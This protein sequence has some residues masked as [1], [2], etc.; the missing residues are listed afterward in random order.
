MK[1][2]AA[3]TAGGA[4]A[5]V[6]QLVLPEP[7]GT[8]L[9]IA[10]LPTAQD[11]VAR[12][13]SARERERL[14]IVVTT[15]VAA[16]Q[17]RIA[18]GEHSRWDGVFM[19]DEGARAA[20]VIE[21]LLLAAEREPESKKLTAYSRFLENLAFRH[22]VSI[23]TAG[24][25]MRLHQQLSYRQLCALGLFVQARPQLEG[26]YV[27]RRGAELEALLREVQELFDMQLLIGEVT[28]SNP[29]IALVFVMEPLTDMGRL[30][31]ELTGARDLPQADL[32]LVRRTLDREPPRLT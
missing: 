18:S 10:V 23:E 20:E 9:G 5:A 1:N 32:E 13:L 2:I 26:S 24:A 17:E 7:Y 4:A 30:F 8:W 14:D 3:G 27:Y 16:I 12:A 29:T 21:M 15:A 11:L 25:L 31:A 6:A 19:P 22:D 28:N